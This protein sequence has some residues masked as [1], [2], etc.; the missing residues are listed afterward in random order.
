MGNQF[1]YIFMGKV[2]QAALVIQATL[3]NLTWLIT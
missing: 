3:A 2:I 1:D